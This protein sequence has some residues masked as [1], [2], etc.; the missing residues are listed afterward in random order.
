MIKDKA[1]LNMILKNMYNAYRKVFGENLIEV[2]LYGSYARGDA[3]ED[4]DIDIVAIVK[5]ERLVLQDKVSEV[6]DI[7]FDLGFE[8]DVIISPTV[9][10]LDEYNECRT[11]IPY[12]KNIEKEGIRINA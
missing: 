10:P 11:F 3:K 4:S 1:L 2:K 9:L 7:A 8:N 5:G 6:R 12:Y